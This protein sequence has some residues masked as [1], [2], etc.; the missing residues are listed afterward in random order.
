MVIKRN[1]TVE[2]FTPDRIR[3]AIRKAVIAS[4]TQDELKDFSNLVLERLTSDVVVQ[5]KDIFDKQTD[6]PSSIK[7]IDINVIQDIVERT[8]IK[9][10]FADTAKAYILYRRK[11]DEIRSTRDSIS[12]TISDVLMSDSKDCDA[13]R[14]NANIDGNTAMGTMLQVGSNVSKNYYLNNMMSKDIAKAHTDGYIHIHD[15]DFYKLTVT[16]CQIDFKKLAKEGFNPGHGYVREPQSISSYATLAAIAIQSNQSDCHGGQSIPNFDYSM[17]PGIYKSF[18]KAWKKNKNKMFLT[19]TCLKGIEYNDIDMNLL[20]NDDDSELKSN[21]YIDSLLVGFDKV[22]TLKLEN[23]TFEHLVYLTNKDIEN[24]C[25]QAME[26]FVHNLNTLHARAGSQLPFSSINLGTDT[27]NAGRMVIKNLLLAME[28]GLGHGE[29][30]IFPIVIFKVKEGVNYNPEDPN[31][32]LLQLSYRVTGKRLFPNYLYLD[33]PFNLQYY[34]PGHPETEVAQMGCVQRDEL[35]TYKFDGKLYVESIGRMYDRLSGYYNTFQ[36]GLSNYLDVNNG[37]VQI[38]DSV[39]G[40]VGCKKVIKN[41]NMNN[42][43]KIKLSNGRVLT[44]TDDHPLPVLTN[45]VFLNRTYARDIN[46]GNA[47]P[48]TYEQYNENNVFVD[49]NS[50]WL[51]GLILCDGCYNTGNL[52]TISLGIDEMEAIDRIRFVLSNNFPK[53]VMKLVDRRIDRGQNYYDIIINFND[54][55]TTVSTLL[56]LFEG[57]QKETRHVPNDVFSW[58]RESKVAFLAGMIDADGYTNA[59]KSRSSGTRIQIG[60]TNKELAYGQMALA[61]AINLEAKMYE[62]HYSSNSNRIRYRVEFP[63]SEELYNHITLSKKK[64]MFDNTI[65]PATFKKGYCA[66]VISIESV[67]NSS[68]N[69]DYS[70]DVETQ[71][72]LFDVSGILSHNCR[73]RVIGNVYDPTREISHSRGNLSFTTI[74]LPMLAIEANHDEKKFYELL[75]KYLELVK[76]Q[77]LERF[78][79]QSHLKVKNLPF[80]M[81]QGVWLDSEKLGPEDEVGEVLKHGSLSIGFVGLAEA[82][83]ALYGHHHGEGQEYWD[84]GYAIVKHMRDY[85]DKVASDMKLNFSVLATPAEGLCGSALRKCKAK[86][87]VIEGVTD[88]EYFTNSNH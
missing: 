24:E 74:N 50:A 64:I 21:D 35:V 10:G 11:R 78:E 68:D 52:V 13:K 55:G 81:G 77:L 44:C 59:K 9:N 41:P 71:S 63:V 69:L 67:N 80:L 18:R 5:I 75:D 65:V 87:G 88:R 39:N 62:N 4:H 16:C 32:D 84:K 22:E 20:K 49:I 26:G 57:L 23:K 12:K 6:Y 58:N 27:S 17:A 73:T 82:L 76:K 14:E 31:Y 37:R 25:Y 51:F 36:R 28:A 85:T 29:T 33:S 19:L 54:N 30:C 61:Q 45:G 60:S 48:V 70:Y 7:S 1:G 34:K 40:F 2:P 3:E 86:Y 15:L 8:L 83:V 72:D 66:K 38:F 53:A 56:Y 46:V 79:I 42:W 47:I 43:L